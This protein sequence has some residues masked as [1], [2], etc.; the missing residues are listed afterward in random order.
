MKPLHTRTVSSGNTITDTA[1]RLFDKT[2]KPMSPDDIYEIAESLKSPVAIPEGG[3]K[4]AELKRRKSSGARRSSSSHSLAG[5]AEE[6]KPPL[7]LEPVEYV[8]MEGDVLLPFVERPEEVEELLIHENNRK[9]VSE[10]KAAFPKDKA[11]EHWQALSPEEWS[12]EEFMRHL[13]LP[14]AQCPDYQ[15]IFRARQA[16]RKRSIAHW[17][18]LG[19]CLGCDGD[20]LNAGGDDGLPSTWGIGAATSDVD[21]DEEDYKGGNQVWIEGLHA[22]DENERAER[23]FAGAFGSIQP[24]S[25]AMGL[26]MM[27][28]IGEDEEEELIPPR[29]TP[30]QRAGNQASIDPFQSQ[31]IQG[32]SPLATSSSLGTSASLRANTYVGLQIMTSPRPGQG[33]KTP[34]SPRQSISLP[35]EKVYQQERSSGDPLF[36]SHFGGLSL[37]PTLGRSEVT[38]GVQAVGSTPIVAGEAR[39]WGLNRKPSGAGLSESES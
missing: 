39:K 13:K 10:I 35:R 29:S 25:P 28:A 27:G 18:K 34:T 16:C 5:M 4:G 37:N 22:V 14:R 33:P 36:V 26:G 31:S 9:W 12:W 6:P 38:P 19:T 7:A 30:A 23:D 3:F 17:E 32:H 21:S 24:D 15:F 20:L 1:N 8:E 2:S 11:R